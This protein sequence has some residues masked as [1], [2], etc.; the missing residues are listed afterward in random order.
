MMN[1]I[2]EL[3]PGDRLILLPTSPFEKC[4]R[5]FKKVENGNV[6]YIKVLEKDPTY[7]DCIGIE[8]FRRN[9]TIDY[10]YRKKLRFNEQLAK[11]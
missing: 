10:S 5:F 9:L 11:I 4:E 1:I 2:S 6:Y 7:L 3:R 8:Y